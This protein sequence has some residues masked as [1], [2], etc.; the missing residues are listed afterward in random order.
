MNYRF[1]DGQKSIDLPQYPDEAWNWLSGKPESGDD[2]I[3][4]SVAWLY[5]AIAMIAQC[6]ADMPFVLQKGSQDW[7]TSADWQNKCGFMTDPKRLIYLIAAS[8]ELAGR[9]YLLR[10]RSKAGIKDLRFLLP[11]S[12]TP[13]IDPMTGLKD[14]TRPVNGRDQHFQPVEDILYFWLPDPRVEIGP[15]E[16]YPA[17]A[18][19]SS[20]GVLYNVDRFASN[21]FERGAIK[22]TILAVPANTPQPER[23]RLEKWWEKF[24]SG[25]KKS[26][27]WKVFNADA[28]KPTVIGEGLEA[29][30]DA[31]AI[32]RAREDIAAAFGISVAMILSSEANYATAEVDRQNLYTNTVIPL[33]NFIAE[34]LNVQLFRPMRMNLVFRPEEMDIFQEDETQRAQ[35]LTAL[36]TALDNPENFLISA[37]ILGY[38]LTDEQRMAI[39][40]L[41][42]EKQLARERMAKLTAPAPKPEEEK[43]AEAP[44]VE[45]NNDQEK[46]LQEAR[47]YK[48][49]AL[50]AVRAGKSADVVFDPVYLTQLQ[51]MNIRDRLANAKTEDEVKAAFAFEI[52]TP[53][54]E[55]KTNEAIL[56]MGLQVQ[57]AIKLGIQ[58]LSFE[59]ERQDERHKHE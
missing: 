5:R 26:F 46:Q 3:C 8:C 20:A 37:D 7:D 31:G 51:V 50:G 47:Q 10:D 24:M 17:K 36:N 32:V 52:D 11:T 29:L 44:P 15:P 40:K 56:A 57:E 43:E 22:A 14:F 33:A 48:H 19:F 16:S 55:A 45:D 2:K 49:K 23:D 35:A 25:V 27:S 38:D 21:F 58:A 39:Q 42:S 6:A 41:I 12:V 59:G 53:Q 18:A 1:F 13:H 28:V 34:T 30:K 9:A 4:K 54:T